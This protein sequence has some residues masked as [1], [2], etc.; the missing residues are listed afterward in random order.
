MNFIFS[1][2]P[3][4]QYY[5]YYR[6]YVIVNQDTVSQ[7]FQLFISYVMNLETLNKC[8][9]ALSTQISK[10]IIASLLISLLN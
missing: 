3:F 8:A 2:K 5:K 1:G 10:Q 6:I 9:H 4:N 7:Y